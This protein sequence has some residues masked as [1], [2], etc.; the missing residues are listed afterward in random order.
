MKKDI[1]SAQKSVKK[2]KIGEQEHHIIYEG[3]F[4]K[5]AA[6]N[7][8]DFFKNTYKDIKTKGKAFLKNLKKKSSTK[9]TTEMIKPGEMST[10]KYNAKDKTKKF[11]KQPLIIALGPAETKGNFYGLNIHWLKTKDRVSVASFFVE[12][13]K[14]RDGQLTYNDIKPFMSKFKGHPV[15]RQY[16]F[17][18]IGNRVIHIRDDELF[19]ST[20]GVDTADWFKP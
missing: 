7:V 1:V 9:K 18:R 5:T 3:D 15:L 19:L 17:K 6:S 4:I 11:D 14:K 16:I 8:K 12:L 10:F 2:A 20:A 13:K